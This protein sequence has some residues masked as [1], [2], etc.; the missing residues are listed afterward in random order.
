MSLITTAQGISNE[1]ATRVLALTTNPLTE[2]EI[3]TRVFR[4]RRKI[5]DSHV[6][7]VAVIEGLDTPKQGESMRRATSQ[8]RQ[9]YVLVGYHKCDP[10]HPNDVGHAIIRDLK[11][12]I[13]FDGTTLNEQVKRVEY[14][15]K[16]IGPR[17]DGASIV[18]ASIE[19]AV[20]FVEDLASP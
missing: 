5:D 12:A 4:G 3:A 19:F 8:T 15:G 7:C 1:I 13:F 6:P 16:D 17:A 10:D 9:T 2:T 20:E 14:L 11:R 18:S